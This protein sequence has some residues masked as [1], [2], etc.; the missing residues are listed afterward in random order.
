[1]RRKKTVENLQLLSSVPTYISFLLVGAGC[2]WL[3]ISALFNAMANFPVLERGGKTFGQFSIIQGSVGMSTGLIYLL[4]NMRCPHC[5]SMRSEQIG[6]CMLICFNAAYCVVLASSWSVGAPNYP[7]FVS[8]AMVAHLVGNFTIYLLFPVVATYY[9]GWLVAPVRA[10]TDLSSLVT[11]LLGQ[12]QNP[13][14]GSGE[15]R[16]SLSTLFMIY[17]GFSICGL[18]AWAAI[19]H[20][21]TG[22]RYEEEEGGTVTLTDSE[23]ETTSS[24]ESEE[25]KPSEE[26]RDPR[27]AVLGK[28]AALFEGFACPR[29]LV[30]PV[31][32]ATLSQV[33]QWG[34]SNAMGQ[35][36][37]TS[38]D[39]ESCEG[40]VGQKV[41]RYALTSSMILVPLGSIMSTAAP[42]P[43]RIFVAISIIQLLAAALIMNASFQLLGSKFS[44][45]RS[46]MEVHGAYGAYGAWG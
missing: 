25:L 45:G 33:A 3:L 44:V 24:D 15:L 13:D 4:W 16:F 34:L 35:I 2:G 43:R 10:G 22:L 46:G 32:L 40:A 30:L 41:Y 1:M 39:P 7:V 21:G 9:A 27:Q 31:V 11:S 18:L 23:S 14:P 36:G 8:G 20:F 42:C 28:R 5:L 29:Q 12:F 6:V 37:A 19:M 17:F 38:T 26:L